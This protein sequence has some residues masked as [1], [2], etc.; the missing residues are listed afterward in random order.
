MKELLYLNKYFL[1]YKLRFGLGILFV[2]LANVLNTLSPKVL[3]YALDLV[4]ENL[5]LFNTFKTFDLQKNLTDSIG[6]SILIFSLIYLALAL[7]GGFFTFLMRQ[8]I[9]V[10]SRFIENDLRNDIYTHYQALDQAFYKRNNTGDLMNR[11]T[12]DVSQV[13]MYIG[14]ALM[15]SINV[16]MLFSFVIYSM[17]R[18]DVMFTFWVL[19]PMPLLI[20]SIYKVQSLI[21]E[22]S[23][24]I[25]EK[26]SDLTTQAQEYYS[27]IRVLK[28]FVQE[29]FATKR[30][31]K[32]SENYMEESLKLARIEAFFFPLMILL[33]GLSTVLV[34]YIGG[35][36]MAEGSI[37]PGNILEFVFYVN[38]LT[39]PISSVGWVATL[40]QSAAASQKR[41]NDF[42][43]TKPTI[44]NTSTKTA[45]FDGEL[46]FDNV[47]FIYPDTGIQAIKNLSFTIKKGEK[48]AIMGKT[49]CGKTTI[50]DLVSRLYDVT[51]GSISISNTN[52]KDLDIEKYRAQLGYVPQDVFLFSDSIEKNIKFSDSNFS[53]EKVQEAAKK[54]S[55]HAEIEKFPKQY[56]TIVGERG[57]TLSGGQK[58]RVA[59]ARVLIKDPEL[60]IFDDS[61]S[62]L[63]TKTEKEILHNLNK[64][65]ADKT[66]IIITHRIP[67]H[68]K[69][70]KILVL[71]N[72][73]CLELGTHE[74]LLANNSFYRS[75]YDKQ[76]EK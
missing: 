3:G 13:R 22:R 61:L 70:D 72:G 11:A 17:L 45:N 74:E 24:T 48:W 30:Y 23:K 19:L 57:I 18:I 9:I 58:Q 28:S 73:E 76:N 62:A 14:P 37:T 39:W 16:F 65:I 71:E 67:S 55:I 75:V 5:S 20:I 68:I 54:A 32:T 42:L 53:F 29:N 2:I 63:D 7:L 26:L 52:I 41:I 10:M 36:K 33:I 44:I 8:S 51:D 35:I 34:V 69:F 64:S 49:G 66:V 46:V 38:M 1:R 50:A 47:N 15:Y 6:K 59:M 21:N 56:E 4:S 12:E 31:E 25:Q 40:I 43:K 60:F 27:G